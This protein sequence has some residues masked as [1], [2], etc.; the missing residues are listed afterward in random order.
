MR[1]PTLLISLIPVVVLV[2]LLTYCIFVF[3]DEM[4]A[5]PSQLVLALATALAGAIAVLWYKTTWQSIE[6]EMVHAIST[7]MPACL[8]ILMMGGICGAWMHSG[9]IPTMIYYGLDI[10][11]PRWLLMTSCILSAV[12]SLCIGS[13]WTTIGTIGVGL[14][15]IG[16]TLGLED[17]WVAGAIIS[18]AYFGDKISPLS[19]TTNLA[20]S[21]TGVPLFTHIKGMLHTTIPSFLIALITYI[22]IGLMSSDVNEG[23]QAIASA[24]GMTTETMQQ[25]LDE[26]FFISPFLLLVP[27]IIFYMIYKGIPAVVTL[28]VG[29][30]IGMFMIMYD[31]GCPT[32]FRAAFGAME[33]NSEHEIINNLTG[34]GGIA[35][36]LNVIWLIIMSM[37]FGAVMEVSGM[38]GCITNALMKIMTGRI[39]TVAI[40]GASGIF[41]NCTTGDQCLAIVLPAKMYH[42]AYDR[43]KF[44]KRLLSRTIEDFGT[45]TSVLVPWNSCGMTQSMV[46]GVSTLVYAPFAIFCWISPIMSLLVATIKNLKFGKSNS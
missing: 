5:G 23:A 16:R 36:M 28:F 42:E 26:T 34:T 10:I 40:T 20:S 8:I 19:E 6:N 13:S 17:C 22:I 30:L 7:T 41:L 32:A 27:I 18:G 29:M 37:S 12:V 43:L 21:V 24:E 35:G 9:I 3:G 45:V 33:G 44:P 14:L 2:A 25:F 39:S 31:A 11:S 4:L 15:G 38:L 1:K 46:L